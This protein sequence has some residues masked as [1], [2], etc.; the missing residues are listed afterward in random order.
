[1]AEE[2]KEISDWEFFQSELAKYTTPTP[3][4]VKEN[5]EKK[6]EGKELMIEQRSEEWFDLRKGKITSSEI[7]KI[8][9]E[10]KAKGDLLGATAKS[11]LMSRVSEKLGGF[12]ERTENKA[13]KWGTAMEPEAIKMFEKKFNV[14]VEEAPFIE[15]MRHY[16]GSPDG[17]IGYDGL[18]EVKSPYNSTNHFSY[19]LIKSVEDFK[20]IKSEYY[21]QC[22][23]NIIVT[24]RSYCTFITFDPRVDTVFQLGTYTIKREEIQD[25][26]N[27][28]LERVRI[29][30]DYMNDLEK[31]LRDS[32]KM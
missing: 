13:T 1:M 6:E 14:E 28:L 3:E 27:Y 2:L 23:S 10:G 21:W 25:D 20:R 26:I 29:A 31:R 8:L 30:G 12:T 9:G 16:G 19:L 7:S 22:V 4:V 5:P 18:I 11:Y 32:V 24:G 15:F 17:L